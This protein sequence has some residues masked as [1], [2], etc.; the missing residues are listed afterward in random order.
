MCPLRRR[1]VI[2]RMSRVSAL[3]VLTAA[4]EDTRFAAEEG[5]HRLPP[6]SGLLQ[7]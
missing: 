7:A 2:L 5:R 1:K 3:A 4:A 6:D